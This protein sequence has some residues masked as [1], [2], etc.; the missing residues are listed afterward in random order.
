[1]VDYYFLSVSVG[2]IYIWTDTLYKNEI[3]KSMFVQLT[4]S[5]HIYG[6][7]TEILDRIYYQGMKID[8]FNNI[9]T[10]GKKKK[11]LQHE[12]FAYGLPLHYSV[13]LLAA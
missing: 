13:S 7:I 11:R 9:V 1:M 10:W 2:G 3:K 12:S 6:G 8:S 4:T 5:K